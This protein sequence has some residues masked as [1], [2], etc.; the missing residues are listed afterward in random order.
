[1]QTESVK[2]PTTII[3]L[4]DA[5]DNVIVIENGAIIKTILACWLVFCWTLMVRKY[6]IISVNLD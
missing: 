4:V 2:L 1:M 5:L 6:S 3:P